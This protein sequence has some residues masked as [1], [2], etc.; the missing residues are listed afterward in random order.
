MPCSTE[1]I[2]AL[3]SG[4]GLRLWAPVSSLRLTT[5]LRPQHF[6]AWLA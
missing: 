6:L 4:T 2:A 1:L 5:R 3:F